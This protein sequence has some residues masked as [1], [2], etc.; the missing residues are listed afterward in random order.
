L[1]FKPHL[2]FK[3]KDIEERTE[4]VKKICKQLWST[5]YFNV[6]DE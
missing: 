2:E 1:D 4:L 3:K 6:E 5:D